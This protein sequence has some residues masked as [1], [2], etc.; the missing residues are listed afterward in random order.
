[1]EFYI[2]KAC[3]PSFSL[4]T[5]YLD[6]VDAQIGISNEKAVLKYSKMEVENFLFLSPEFKVTNSLL[7]E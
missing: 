5:P 1:M 3:D 7:L 6:I 4:K 2:R